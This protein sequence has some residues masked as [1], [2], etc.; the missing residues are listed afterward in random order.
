MVKGKNRFLE[1]RFLLITVIGGEVLEELLRIIFH[2]NGLLGSN[3]TGHARYTFPSEQSL[4]AVVTYGFAAFII[5]RHIKSKWIGTAI[6]TIVLIICFFAGLSPLF[7]Q[8]QYPSDVFAGYVFGGVWLSLNII[9]LEL[10]RILPNI[11]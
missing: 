1:L 9:C 6:T 11:E 4:M 2:R 7:F 8:L 10:L 3:I 5:L